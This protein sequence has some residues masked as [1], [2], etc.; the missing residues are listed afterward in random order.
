MRNIR[1]NGEKV[2]KT[3]EK[4]SREDERCREKR[5]QWVINV[6]LVFLGFF[7]GMIFEGERLKA[8]VVTNTVEIRIL[9]R[10]LE[11]IQE[12]LGIIIEGRAVGYREN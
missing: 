4:E 3:M 7:A 12:K 10:S 8:Q 9:K 5:Y 2:K 11:D 6:L 1:Q